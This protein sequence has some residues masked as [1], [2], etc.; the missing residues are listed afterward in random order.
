MLQMT[1]RKGRVVQNNDGIQ[2][3]SRSESDVPLEVLNL[4]EKQRFM[5]GE[6]V[7]VVVTG[8]DW[9]L[10]VEVVV[11]GVVTSDGDWWWWLVVTGADWW[12]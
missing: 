10:L 11:T 5:D 1:G 8:G 7:L 12:W 9:R 6:K 2:Y 4:T 3:E